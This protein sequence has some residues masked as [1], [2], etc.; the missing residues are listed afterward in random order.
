VLVVI[1]DLHFEEEKTDTI[2]CPH[3]DPVIFRRN[4]QGRA[5][6]Q[7]IAKLASEAKRN[8][9][10][11]LDMVLAGDIFDLNRTS[12]WFDPAASDVRP[13]ASCNQVNVQLEE[14]V[15]RILEAIAAETEVN[16]ALQALQRLG[17]NQS[18]L[19]DPDDPASETAFPVE[20]EIHYLPGNHDRLANA[21]DRIRARVQDLLGLPARQGKF[22]HELRFADPAVLIRH[23]HEYD[24][25]NFSADHRNR[26]PVFPGSFP[27]MEYDEPTL[28]DFITVEVAVQLAVLF[29]QH[30]EDISSDPVKV[31]LYQR[32][33]EFDDVRPQS[34]I[35]DFLLQMP[36]RRISP[37][38]VWALLDPIV[39]VLLEKIH[40]SE[41]LRGWLDKL[42][43]A[44]HLDI[45]DAVKLV[46]AQDWLIEHL[47][48]PLDLVRKTAAL[49]GKGGTG[50]PP[51]AYAA[52]EAT[53]RSGDVRFVVAGHTHNPAT[54]LI[55][56]AK[57]SDRYYLDTGTWRNRVLSTPDRSAFGRLKAL[58]YAVIYSSREDL[59]D[60][61]A[62]PKLESLDYWSGFT[63]R[64]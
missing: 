64:W 20:V 13:Y 1:S 34:A 5:Y 24:R 55:S 18:Y 16:T 11:R 22:P 32:L 60:I 26:P 23:G 41:F 10:M 33:L 58:T 9:A 61:L 59:G 51:Q 42:N 28:G 54:E 38:Q 30:C 45:M 49:V 37:E 19:A 43:D 47:T 2:S 27:A 62:G 35:V 40:D 12:M 36:E 17:K 56:V 46:L 48:L 14:K 29:R 53:V 63:Q 25:Y 6:T 8:G 52:R 4:I 15:L 57:N 31:Q 50:D 39:H 44:W 7:F 21:T 3:R